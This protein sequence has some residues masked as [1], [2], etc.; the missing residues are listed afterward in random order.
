MPPQAFTTY[1]GGSS[2]QC[3]ARIAS[4]PKRSDSVWR[5]EIAIILLVILI[6]LVV[7]DLAL[8]RALRRKRD[9]SR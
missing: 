9:G 8:V 4:E 3:E 5:M 1:V 2:R 7:G 6:G